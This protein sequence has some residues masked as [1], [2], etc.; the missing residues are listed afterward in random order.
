MT[1]L[2]KLLVP[3]AVG[4]IM[5]HGR[6]SLGG[7]VVRG[8][9]VAGLGAA[10]LI[11]AYGLDGEQFP[12]GATPTHVDVLR[13][14]NHPLMEL[15]NPKSVGERPWPTYDTGFLRHTTLIPVWDLT[16]TRVPMGA[17]VWRIPAQG[18]QHPVVV[19][20]SPARGWKGTDAYSPPLALIG[21]RARWQGLELQA[22]FTPDFQSVELLHL[23]DA[24]VPEGFEQTRPQV[25]ARVVPRAECD[26]IFETNVTATWRDA[27]V[28]VL[29]GG[30]EQ[31][32]LQLIEPDWPT[33]QRLGAWPT[34]PSLFEVAAPRAEVSNTSGTQR[35]LPA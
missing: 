26:V 15:T 10:D 34:E 4:Q 16:T 12:F 29:Q 19:F 18:E 23:G 31:V 22:E 27:P 3:W 20:D 21:P 30:D 11:R 7:P 33:V 35:E 13:F 17:E 9:D 8:A 5:E 25:Y 1:I 6:T 32:L 2:Q 14:N 28:R 24:N